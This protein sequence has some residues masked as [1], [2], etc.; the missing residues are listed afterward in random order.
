MRSF[1]LGPH[2][3]KP[4][5]Y[6]STIALL[7]LHQKKKRIQPMHPFRGY[8]ERLM[9]SRERPPILCVRNFDTRLM[10]WNKLLNRHMRKREVHQRKRP[11]KYSRVIWNWN[12]P[13]RTF[14]RSWRVWVF[15][16]KER[17]GR[18][19]KEI[20]VWTV[21]DG[22]KLSV[23]SRTRKKRKSAKIVNVQSMWCMIMWGRPR[24]TKRRT[25]CLVVVVVSVTIPWIQKI[26][27]SKACWFQL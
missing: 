5:H 20:L 27:K 11:K 22:L 14:M 4:Y 9:W 2:D 8:N 19:G 24:S 18:K 10:H 3:S 23:C 21:Y 13:R 26:K 17:K 15:R 25:F 12:G 16:R 1:P 6:L 7:L